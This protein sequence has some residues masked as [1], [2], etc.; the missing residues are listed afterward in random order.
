VPTVQ[1]FLSHRFLLKEGQRPQLISKIRHFKQK[2]QHSK[3][4]FL[5]T[6]SD[7]P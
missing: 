3:K 2:I 5:A 7:D 6:V 1:G 4:L